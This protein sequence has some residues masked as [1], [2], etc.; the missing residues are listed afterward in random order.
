MDGVRAPR[1]ARLVAVAGLAAVCLA[2]PHA[3]R[4]EL[5]RGVAYTTYSA[6]TY[7]A[8]AS[9]ASL[10][11]LAGDG[12]SHVAI[13]VTRYMAN[14]Y[15]IVEKLW[16]EIWWAKEFESRIKSPYDIAEPGAAADG[17]SESTRIH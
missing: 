11:R 4:A 3:A 14:P 15:S 6:N 5:Q 2:Q 12:N 13:V 17:P 8:A 9:D 10:A 16:G 1:R 7:G